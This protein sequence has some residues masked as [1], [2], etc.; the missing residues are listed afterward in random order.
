MPIGNE[1]S[2]VDEP[3]D[4]ILKPWLLMS[5]SNAHFSGFLDF[6]DFHDSVE[7]KTASTGFAAAK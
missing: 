3:I 6:F 5:L 1:I 7:D 2:M 4:L